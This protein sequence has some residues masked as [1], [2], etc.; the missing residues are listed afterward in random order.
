ME[1][2]DESIV[3][4]TFTGQKVKYIR[5]L[6]ECGCSVYFLQNRPQICRHCGRTVYPTKK[7]KFIDKLKKEMRKNK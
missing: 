7:C 2:L 5:T 1:E 6:C 4:S 3:R